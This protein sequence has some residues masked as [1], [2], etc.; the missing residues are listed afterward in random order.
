MIGGVAQTS[1]HL[2]AVSKL[3]RSEAL[4]GSSKPPFSNAETVGKKKA[5]ARRRMTPGNGLRKSPYTLCRVT[6]LH[7]YSPPRQEFV[8]YLWRCWET[9]IAPDESVRELARRLSETHQIRGRDALHLAI[10]E[11]SG[12]DYLITCDDQLVRQGE[13]LQEQGVITVR[14]INPVDFV[15]EA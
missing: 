8:P 10:A 12:C 7:F 1:N 2:R 5:V 3:Y 4:P 9:T 6:Q 13:R 14:V 11:T 15:Q